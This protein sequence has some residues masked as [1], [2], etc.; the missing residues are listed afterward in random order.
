MTLDLGQRLEQTYLAWLDACL[1]TLDKLKEPEALPDD[2]RD[3][4]PTGV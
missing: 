1:T 2:T 4:G 3:K